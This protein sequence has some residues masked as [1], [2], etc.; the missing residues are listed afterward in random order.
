MFCQNC[1]KGLESGVKFCGGCGFEVGGTKTNTQNNTHHHTKERRF[2][3]K[4]T[5]TRFMI[6]YFATLGTYPLFWMYDQW[7]FLKNKQNL[8]ISPGARAFF[9]SLWAGSL[10]G[11]VQKYLK[12]ENINISYSPALIGVSY[13]ILSILY[14]LPDPYWL[15]ALLSFMPIL[16]ILD[17]MNQYYEKHDSHLQESKLAWWQNVLIGI[18]LLFLAAGVYG[19]I[20][21]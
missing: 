2:S 20:Y 18:G 11:E 3:G 16:P 7:T 8:N 9:S 12:K 13:F 5:T 15:I 19:T 17:A 1:G 6:L 4:R 21:P 14:K 10:A